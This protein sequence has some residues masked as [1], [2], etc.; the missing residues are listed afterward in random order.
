MDKCE[1][2]GP[3]MRPDQQLLCRTDLDADGCTGVSDKIVHGLPLDAD[4]LA[5]QAARERKFD[6]LERVVS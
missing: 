1:G 6:L 4:E 3:P 5:T 2:A